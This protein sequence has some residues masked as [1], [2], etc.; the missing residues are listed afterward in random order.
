MVRQAHHD[1]IRILLSIASGSNWDA[2]DVKLSYQHMYSRSTHKRF[3]RETLSD[4]SCGALTQS[5][6]SSRDYV[7]YQRVVSTQLA[8]AHQ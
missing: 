8:E 4:R 6:H 5:V 3:T 1:G 2:L 7:S